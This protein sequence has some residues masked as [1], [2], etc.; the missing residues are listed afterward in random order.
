[1]LELVPR[2][3]GFAVELSRL[4]G[5][6]WGLGL[7]VLLL[8]DCLRPLLCVVRL[9]GCCGSRLCFAV[10]GTWERWLVAGLLARLG[11]GRLRDALRQRVL[12][13]LAFGEQVLG[14]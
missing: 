9:L 10:V 2:I 8:V 14:L 12:V 3:F 11:G 7:G 1:M 13:P 6:S 4:P 5:G